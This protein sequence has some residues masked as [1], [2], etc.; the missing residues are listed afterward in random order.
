LILAASDAVCRQAE[1]LPHTWYH[2]TQPAKLATH[3]YW[4]YRRAWDVVFPGLP[5]FRDRK[6]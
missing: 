1:Q 4:K 3:E 5:P 6:P 2:L